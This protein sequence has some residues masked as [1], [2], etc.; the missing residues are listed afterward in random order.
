[1]RDNSCTGWCPYDLPAPDA[2]KVCSACPAEKP[3]WS[4]DKC[5]TCADASAGKTPFWSPEFKECYAVCPGHTPTLEDNVTCKSCAEVNPK[6]PYLSPDLAD[7]V[8]C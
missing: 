3:Y 6:A 2:N 1:M 8:V 7:C 4:D 5:R